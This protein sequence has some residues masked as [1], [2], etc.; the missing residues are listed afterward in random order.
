MYEEFTAKVTAVIHHHDTGCY[1]NQDF[2][3]TSIKKKNE[4]P[5]ND[6]KAAAQ[7]KINKTMLYL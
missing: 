2:I 6:K 1:G 3:T 7:S 5:E 4:M